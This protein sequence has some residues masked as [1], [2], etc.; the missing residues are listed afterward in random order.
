MKILIAPWGNPKGWRETTYLFENEKFKSKSSI[1]SLKKVIKPDITLIFATDTLSQNGANWREV[2]GEVKNYLNEFCEKELRIKDIFIKV[3]PGV[4]FFKNNEIGKI[5]IFKGNPRD[6]YYLLYKFLVEFFIDKI[7]EEDNLEIH[8]DTTHGINYMTI[9][10]YRA[11]REFCEL[12]SFFTD[13]NFFVYNTDPA[14]PFGAIEKININKIEFTKVSPNFFNKSLNKKEIILFDKNISSEKRREFFKKLL[15]NDMDISSFIGS[16]YN[17]IPLGVYTFFPNLKELENILSKIFEIYFDLLEV[18]LVDNML[19]INKHAFLSE[20]YKVLIITYFLG[21]M[22]QKILNIT[23]KDVLNVE[24]LN[25]LNDK[26]FSVDNRFYN[27]IKN[28][29]YSISKNLKNKE[30]NN[31]ML[32]NNFY[33]GK[34]NNEIDKRNFLAHSGFERNAVKVLKKDDQLF[35]KYDEE[36]IKTI[37]KIVMEGLYQ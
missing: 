28:D 27:R 25:N 31:W 37:K 24:D 14:F 34:S 19:E 21:K 3:F 33:A 30:C 7:S 36:K 12:L 5:C 35:F 29:L 22:F 13:V 20:G 26:F 8:I 17:G 9:L 2:E 16:I 32:L 18:K 23:K 10:T 1:L 4:G 6:Y 11:I 15:I